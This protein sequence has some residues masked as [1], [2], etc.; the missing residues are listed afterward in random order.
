MWF[1]YKKNVEQ[2]FFF[3]FFSYLLTI[4]SEIPENV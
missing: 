3:E 1:K 2:T 4:F